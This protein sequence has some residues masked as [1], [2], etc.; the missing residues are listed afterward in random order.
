MLCSLNMALLVQPSFLYP[1]PILVING[2]YKFLGSDF[3]VVAVSWMVLNRE[4]L[5]Q[6]S[7]TLTLVVS[8]FYL[9]ILCSILRFFLIH[10]YNFIVSLMTQKT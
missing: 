2:L 9:T 4:R 10:N 3:H 8:T 5:F 7:V 1:L 6:I